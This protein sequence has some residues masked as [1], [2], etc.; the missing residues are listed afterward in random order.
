[1]SAKKKF[2]LQAIVDGSLR[3]FLG[4]L[5]D[6]FILSI[7]ASNLAFEHFVIIAL[8][9]GILSSTLYWV[10]IRKENSN[11]SII[12]FSLL[13]M[14]GCIVSYGIILMLQ[15]FGWFV[16]LPVREVNNADGLIVMM[17]AGVYLGSAFLMRLAIFIWQIARNSHKKQ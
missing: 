12:I 17:I 8:I 5:L 10:F 7:Y 14:G 16:S 2:Y 3:S 13:S 1:M 4:S 11:K 15:I 9:C 6:V